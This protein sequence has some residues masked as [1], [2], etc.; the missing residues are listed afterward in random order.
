[1]KESCS[2]WIFSVKDV[3]AFL[4]SSDETDGLCNY[5]IRDIF[6]SF[7]R[8]RIC[9][10]SGYAGSSVRTSDEDLLDC[11]HTC[12]FPKRELDGIT[13]EESFCRAARSVAPATDAAGIPRFVGFLFDAMSKYVCGRSWIDCF[14]HGWW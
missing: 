13:A 5:F 14:F 8:Q 7:V 9:M 4:N 6:Q 10:K 12:G 11:L 1:M 2:R 3:R